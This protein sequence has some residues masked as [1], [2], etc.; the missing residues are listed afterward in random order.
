MSRFLSR[1]AAAVTLIAGSVFA[2]P[3]P[4]DA[5]VPPIGAEPIRVM[6]LGDSITFG[7]GTPQQ[8]S[9]RTDLY[10]RLTRAGLSVDFVGSQRSGTGADP[11]NEGHPGWTIAQLSEQLDGW[12][13]TYSP[14]VILLHIGTNDM[15]RNLPGA[16]ERLAALLDQIEAD[17]PRAQVFVSKIIGIASSDPAHQARNA[18]YNAAITR[19]VAAKGG[20]F[21]LVDQSAVHGID[22]FDRVHPNAYGFRR[23]SWTWYRALEPYLT[24]GVRAWPTGDNPAM[25]ASSVRCIEMIR[26][27]YAKY[28]RGCHRWYHDRLNG[29]WRLPIR[30]SQKYT[31]KKLGRSVV[32]NRL[33]VRWAT[34]W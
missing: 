31:I 17:A 6:P 8:D 16:A 5:S 12:L 2:T 3:A 1:L 27:S 25:D 34:A 32:R 7:I 26:T 4:A 20:N 15:Y 28:A 23:M 24:T 19:L 9:Y 10:R 14:D 11:D 33:V 18:A 22:L 30:V 13:A 21:R 29:Q